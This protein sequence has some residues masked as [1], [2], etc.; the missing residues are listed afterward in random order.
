MAQMVS[1]K[2][3]IGMICGDRP[4][5]WSGNDRALTLSKAARLQSYGFSDGKMTECRSLKNSPLP[6]TAF[7]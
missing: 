1:L 7:M 3:L 6:I 5:W 4:G 2:P